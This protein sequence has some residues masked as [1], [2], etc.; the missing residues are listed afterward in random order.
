ML[1][2]G[3]TGG[4]ACGKSTVGRMMMAL[5]AAG[6]QVHILD[7]DRVAHE[8]MQPGHPVYQQVVQAFGQGIL[9]D[10]AVG[11]IDRAKLAEIAF[12][13]P[14]AG[15]GRVQELNRLVHP[16]VIACQDGWM[17]EIGSRDPHGIAV[18]EAA[19]MFE[20]GA[21]G[22]FDKVVTVTCDLEQ[23][24]LRWAARQNVDQETAGAEVR[25]RMAAQWPDD[26]RAVASDYVIDNSGGLP[27]TEAAVQRLM[28]EL[29]RLSFPP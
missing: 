9:R 6:T 21:A 2:V 25:R 7:A 10:D 26:K 4:I 11:T 8:L 15:G 12:G 18:V 28:K 5:A 20:S 24:I 17:D 22:R 16:A 14:G 1:R 29:Q 23:R 19:L 3:L 13:K 27:A